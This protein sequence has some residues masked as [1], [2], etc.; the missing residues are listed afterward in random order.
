ME[1]AGSPKSR[2]TFWGAEG[3]LRMNL[4]ENGKWIQWKMENVK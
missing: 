2:K 3:E 1:K 4:M